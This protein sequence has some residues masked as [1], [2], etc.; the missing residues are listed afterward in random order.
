MWPQ[1]PRSHYQVS[2]QAA[3]CI[4]ISTTLNPRSVAPLHPLS[5]LLPSSPFPYLTCPAPVGI[6]HELINPLPP[7]SPSDHTEH[8]H[9]RLQRERESRCVFVVVIVD[10]EVGIQPIDIII[11]DIVVS[12][13]VRMRR[14]KISVSI[15]IYLYIEGR[16]R[17]LKPFIP[18]STHRPN[19]DSNTRPPARPAT[20][21]LH[22]SSSLPPPRD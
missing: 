22:S 1:Q 2:S 6:R 9:G 18:W 21:T 20:I 12:V 8:N 19:R 16:R 3:N 13:G 4:Y 10:E 11:C 14:I 17:C 15:S 7:S 5:I